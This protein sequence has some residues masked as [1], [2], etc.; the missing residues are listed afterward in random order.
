M[1][2]VLALA[3]CVLPEVALDG[4]PCPCVEGFVCD[5]RTNVCVPKGVD[6]NLDGGPR[7]G[8]PGAERDGGDDPNRDAGE[9]ERD[10]GVPRDGGPGRDGGPRDAGIFPDCLVDI[11]CASPASTCVN[12]TCVPGCGEAGGPTCGGAETCVDARCIA[13][14][15]ACMDS[16][17]CG[18]GP[19]SGVCVDGACRP[20]CGAVEGTCRGDRQCADDGFCVVAPRCATQG[21]CGHPD[22]NCIDQRCVRRCDRPYGYPCHGD[23]TCDAF[24]RCTGLGVGAACTDDDA[25]GTGYCLILGSPPVESYCTRPCA[26]TSD[27]PLD[28]T[29]ARVDGAKQCVR[30]T[31]FSGSQMLDTPTGGACTAMVN[32]C[33]SQLCST[34]DFCLERCSRDENCDPFDLDCVTIELDTQNGTIFLNACVTNGGFAVGQSCLNND[35]CQS[36]LC[37]RYTEQCAK[38]CCS[39]ADC[40]AGDICTVYD[41]ATAL[42]LTVCLTPGAP[43]TLEYGAACN[44]NTACR[45]GLCVPVDPDNQAGPK[46]CTTYCCDDFDCGV[47]P[48]GGRCATLDG[49]IAN[50]QTKVCVP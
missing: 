33:Q 44:N 19:P 18:D 46:A 2:V 25:C 29:C 8:G 13:V 20:G 35:Q 41:L 9:V 49:P 11:D 36:G 45:S 48:S 26:A 17:E 14:G 22:Y 43:G 15:A 39:G 16:S 23:S 28:F 50:A 3:G 31:S 12:Q 47:L 34:G 30:E 38:P 5:T 6:P 42:P 32:T 7:D 21:D 24:G 27:C 37:N 40:A 4:R 10:G 1:F